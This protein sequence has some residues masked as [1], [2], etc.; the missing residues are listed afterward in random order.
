MSAGSGILHSEHN[1]STADPVHLLQVWLLPAER[2]LEPS[3]EQ[4]S[5]PETELSG[6]LRLVAARDGRLGALNIH[7]DAD[8]YLARLGPGQSVTHSLHLG[9]A[10]WI[11]VGSGRISL[12]GQE[13]AEGDGAAIEQEP[14]LNITALNSAE[15][16][17]FDL[18]P[19]R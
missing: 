9:R 16:L 4:K 18:G 8:V 3:Y 12:N 13:L 5:F 2:G 11:Q 19:G 17:L 14:E 1:A 10:G 6:R 15:L 7:Q